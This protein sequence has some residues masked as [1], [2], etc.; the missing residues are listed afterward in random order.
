MRALVYHGPK[1]MRIDKVAD[2]VVKDGEN[3]IAIRAVGIC[4][5]DMHG[6]LG[7][8]ERRPAPLIL[9]HEGAGDVIEGPMKG[10]RVTVNPLVPCGDCWAC[11]SAR[12]HLCPTRQLISMPPREGAFAEL[13]TMPSENL[14]EVPD[15]VPFEI[16]ALTEP[17]AVCYHAV[18][19]AQKH[20]G[21]LAGK[22]CLVIGGGAIGLGSALCLREAGATDIVVSEPNAL[23]HGA[24]TGAGFEVANPTGE[25]QVIIDAVGIAVTRKVASA[26][27]QGGGV[28]VHLGLG[29]AEPGLDVRK[30]TLQEITFVGSYC[31]T[32]ADFRETAQ[33]LF[34]GA[35]GE[36]N[37]TD[38]RPLEAGADAFAE[39][40]AGKTAM[41]KVILRP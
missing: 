1:E 4:G 14:V 11:N 2:P 34:E 39:I 23:R 15:D 22:R 7:H 29:D 36:I 10:K 16:A 33:K 40:L 6:Y 18:K 41:P 5:S 3:L 35:F 13:L 26:H 25:Y 19:L 37:W 9:G 30:L 38:I 27:A 32:K 17:M 12:E 31:Y 21:D 24:I 8:D 20:G 28:I